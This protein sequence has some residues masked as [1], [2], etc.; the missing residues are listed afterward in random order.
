MS[1]AHVARCRKCHA[2]VGAAVFDGVDSLG[3]ALDAL[4]FLAEG[5]AITMEE[6]DS[7]RQE[8]CRCTTAQQAAGP[9]ITWNM[10]EDPPNGAAPRLRLFADR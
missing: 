9:T 4:A 8:E 3:W 6:I 2:V 10:S 5:Y 1:L 7:F